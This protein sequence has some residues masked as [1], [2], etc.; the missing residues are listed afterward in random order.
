MNQNKKKQGS[1]FDQGKIRITIIPG[2]A[3]AEVMK[4]G[5]FG[6]KKYGDLNYK[7]GMPVSKYIDAAFR[8]IFI[9]WWWFGIDYDDE[10]GLH[11]LAHGSWNVLAALEQM[12]LK[13]ELDNRHKLN[14]HAGNLFDVFLKEEKIVLKNKKGKKK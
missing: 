3:I 7:K 14:K 6:A 12:I 4:V 5:E 2:I 9:K 10:S 1:K 13:P 11:H 8:H